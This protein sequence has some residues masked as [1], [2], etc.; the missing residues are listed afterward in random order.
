MAMVNTVTGPLDSSELGFTLS[1]EHVLLTSA[2]IKNVF[3]QFIDRDGVIERA[4]QALRTAYGEGVRT[5]VDATTMDLGRDI[6]LLEQVSRESG[7]NVVCSTGILI[8]IPRALWLASPDQIVSLF[9]QE[10]RH[11]I[12]GTGV[13][14][15]VIK[16]A[17]HTGG[18]SPEGE[19]TLRA[20]ARASR[21]TG[22]PI[23][24]HTYAA[25]R[26]GDLQIAIFE[27][28]GVKLTNVYIGHSDDSTDVEYLMGML[29]KGV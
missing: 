28:E 6:A 1:H 4:V 11:G 12:E 5:I 25:E 2:G 29:E 8:D 3:P 27:E 14:P 19:T 24:T 9:V 26:A 18:V 16:V 10:I 21:E 15:G 17:T 23:T 13:K 7:V 22:A 20:A